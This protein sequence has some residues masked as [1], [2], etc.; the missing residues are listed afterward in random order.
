[1]FS[2]KV[3]AIINIRDSFELETRGVDKL[4]KFYKQN[5]T[6]NIKTEE[7]RKKFI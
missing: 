7:G 6:F 4:L 5:P 3:D 2:K 1:M